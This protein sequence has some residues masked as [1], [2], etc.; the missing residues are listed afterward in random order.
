MMVASTDVKPDHLPGPRS[1]AQA[2]T[3]APETAPGEPTCQRA[4]V[5]VRGA[6]LVVIALV[7]CA[8]A[9]R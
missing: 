6:A 4:L 5:H 3:A 2:K 9:L 7:A 8:C 1:E